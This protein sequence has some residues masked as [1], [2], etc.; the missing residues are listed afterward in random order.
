MIKINNK[1]DDKFVEDTISNPYC[2]A[3]VLMAMIL[4]LVGMGMGYTWAG[5]GGLL[6]GLGVGIAIPLGLTALA[7]VTAPKKESNEIL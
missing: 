7:C 6:I 4:P 3:V 5:F 1:T 2:C